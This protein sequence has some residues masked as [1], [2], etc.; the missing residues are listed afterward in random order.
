[1]TDGLLYQQ[2]I[3]ALKFSPSGKWLLAGGLN[4]ATQLWNVASKTLEKQY[5]ADNGKKRS[6]VVMEEGRPDHQR[7]QLFGRRMDRRLEVRNLRRGQDYTCIPVEFDEADPHTQ[8]SYCT[9]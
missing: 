3:L 7:R 8:A 6:S 4:P 5:P 1:M 9:R 2:A